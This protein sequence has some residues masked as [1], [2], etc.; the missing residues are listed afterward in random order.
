MERVAGRIPALECIK[1]G[2]RRVHRMLVLNDAKGLEPLFDAAPGIPIER[3]PRVELNKLVPETIHQGVVL[4]A[5]PLPVINADDWAHWNHPPDTV[6]VIL[7]GIED[8]HNFGAIIRSA[9]A[10]GAGA[11]LFSKDRSAP[12]SAVAV[13]SAAG[14]VEHIALVQAVN[15]ARVLRIMKEAGFWIAGLDERGATPLWEA[16]LSGRVGLIIGSEG[17][18]MR[19]LTRDLCDYTLRIPTQGPIASLNASVSAGI[20][21]AECLRQ[22]Q[23]ARK[24]I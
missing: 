6:A 15:L 21:L 14:A 24:D 16:S 10:C 2:K 13:K 5:D 11:V 1:A 7:D 19:R 12:L 18:G 4:L 20:V 23:T 8:P 22:R 17:K 3:V 9:A